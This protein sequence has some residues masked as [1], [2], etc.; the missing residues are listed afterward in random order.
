VAEPAAW[1]VVA[2]AD[3]DYFERVAPEG[4]TFPPHCPDRSFAVVG[5]QVRI[6]RRSPSRG[7][8]PEIDLSGAPEDPAISHLHALLLRQADGTYSVVDPG[9]TNGTTLNSGADPIEVNV[10]V[11]VKDG[12]RIHIGAWTTLTLHAL[13]GP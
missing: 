5:P 8:A 1:E 6:G 7:V 4:V 11:P 10:A 3:R 9:S 13:S 2:T 12:D